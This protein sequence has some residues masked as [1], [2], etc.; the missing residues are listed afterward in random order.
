[1]ESGTIWPETSG[2]VSPKYSERPQKHYFKIKINKNKASFGTSTLKG[3]N[4][5]WNKGEE[6]KK[7]LNQE[8]FFT[9]I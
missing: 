4:D 6:I 5:D 2:T 7:A 9:D 8:S 1:M 3:I